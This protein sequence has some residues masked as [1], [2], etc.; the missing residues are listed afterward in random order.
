MLHCTIA[1]GSS[2]LA[3]RP[4]NFAKSRSHRTN[5]AAEIR[6]LLN[7]MKFAYLGV[8]QQ[9][10]QLAQAAESAG[11]DNVWFG[12]VVAGPNA[13]VDQ[14]AR[15]EDSWRDL[16]DAATADA[17]VV[18]RGRASDELRAEQLKE[19]AKAGQS[20]LIVH[21]I[22]PSVLG[23]YEIDLSRGES[24][25]LFR[26]YNPLSAMPLAREVASWVDR[27]DAPIGPIEQVVAERQLDQRTPQNV[28]HHFARDVQWLSD[29]AGPFNRLGSHGADSGD[30]AYAGLA[31][32]L[33]GPSQTPVRW[34]VGPV[35]AVPGLRT[36]LIGRLGRL[37]VEIDQDNQPTSVRTQIGGN[38]A[39]L[40]IVRHDPAAAAVD[41]LVAAVES[42]SSESNFADALA[43]ME[44]TDTI[45]ISLRRGRMIDV[46]HQQL[47]EQLAFKGAMSAVGCGALL[48]LPPLLVFIGWVAGLL[49]VPIAAYWPHALA[50]LFALFAGLQIVPKLLFPSNSR[51]PAKNRS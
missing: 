5:V 24:G 37:V 32:Q 46:H 22:I 4:K 9:C 25:A 29:I 18:G 11:H 42:E 33:A 8:D 31:V 44:L 38:V 14:F 3:V 2:S 16:F 17:I 43:A 1:L 23:Y 7:P 36:V 26:C 47:T 39:E 12:D 28:L 20:V 13:P 30:A 34:S 45:E 19:L 41:A 6:R 51:E 40:E 35:D 27:D 10:L 50:I 49:G 21:P 15:R 48:V